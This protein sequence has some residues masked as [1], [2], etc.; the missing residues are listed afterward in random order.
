ML[1]TAI[2]KANV[3]RKGQIRTRTR[4]LCPELEQVVGRVL[5][6]IALRHGADKRYGFRSITEQPVW[7]EPT[8][9][10]AVKAYVAL[11]PSAPLPTAT[12][13][14]DFVRTCDDAASE[15]FMLCSQLWL[16]QCIALLGGLMIAGHT[17]ACL[18]LQACLRG[19]PAG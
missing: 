8:V 4:K 19:N 15:K 2:K 1:N 9:F 10:V 13:L 14:A 3:S 7:L 16:D 6:A 5:H 12:V 11:H 18:R 17:C